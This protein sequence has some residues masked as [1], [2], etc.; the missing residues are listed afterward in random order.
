MSYSKFLFRDKIKSEELT[1]SDFQMCLNAI[2]VKS[3]SEEVSFKMNCPFTKELVNINLNLESFKLNKQKKEI[4]LNVNESFIFTF[5]KPKVK[6]LL[7][8][9]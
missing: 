5:T 8:R 1:I 4:K 9:S 6:D 3:I 2:R 7:V